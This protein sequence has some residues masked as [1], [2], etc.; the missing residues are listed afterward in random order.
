MS[1]KNRTA[2][3]NRFTWHDDTRLRI[4]SHS[5]KS[6]LLEHETDGKVGHIPKS[7]SE[8]HRFPNGNVTVKLPDWFVAKIDANIYFD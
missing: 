3:A 8:V 2:R 4:N 6:W 5:D 7:I 1:S